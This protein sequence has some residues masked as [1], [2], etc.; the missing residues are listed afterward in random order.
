VN[1]VTI[2]QIVLDNRFD[3]RGEAACVDPV[4]FDRAI[5]QSLAYQDAFKKLWP[6]FGF[7]LAECRYNAT[8][9]GVVK[10]D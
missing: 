9:A 4:N 1:R 3:V 2:C 5:G 7:L 6:L 10:H 8:K